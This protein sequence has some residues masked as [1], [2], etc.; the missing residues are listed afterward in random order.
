MKRADSETRRRILAR[1]KFG[2]VNLCKHF[3]NY[4]CILINKEC[5]PSTTSC[6]FEYKSLNNKSYYNKSTTDKAVRVSAVILSHN[7]KCT[8][9]NHKQIDIKAVFKVLIKNT[10]DIIEETIPAAYCKK[11]DQYIILKNDFNI[12]KQ[13]GTLLCQVIDKTPE[14]LSKHR[15][16]S[17]TTESRVHSL[18][19]NVIRQKYNY[20]FKQ[21]KIILS[22]IMEN[23]NVSKHEILSMLDT[24]I[25]RKRNVPSYANAVKKWMEDREFV[26]SYKTGDIP[27][28]IIDEVVIGRR[29]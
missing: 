23:Y 6:H 18:V 21:R 8:Y 25:A 28:V 2:K 12:V 4:C 9:E 11:C 19:Y 13:K 20:S 26:F 27:E 24:N 22:N 3:Q 16:S 15:G 7:R 17:N 1:I 29:M 10:D 14:Y 5:D